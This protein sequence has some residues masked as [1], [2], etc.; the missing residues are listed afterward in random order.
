MVE[1]RTPGAGARRAW[2]L[3]SGSSAAGGRLLRR[4]ERVLGPALLL[5]DALALVRGARRGLGHDDVLVGR[6]R[7]GAAD[8]DAV[9]VGEDAEQLQVL[10]GDLLVAHLA[11]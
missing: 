7:D 11:G 3:T 5:A 10:D 4:L 2:K 9:V 1:K 6:A 8:Q